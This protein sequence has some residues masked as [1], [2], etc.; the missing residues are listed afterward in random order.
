M[1]KS[2][3]DTAHHNPGNAEHGQDSIRCRKNVELGAADDKVA[4]LLGIRPT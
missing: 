4:E 3:G 1:D 2:T